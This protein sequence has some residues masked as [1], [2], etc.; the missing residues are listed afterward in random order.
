MVRDIGEIGGDPC[1]GRRSPAVEVIRTGV[2]RR[3]WTA[4]DKPSRLLAKC[5]PGLVALAL[6][7]LKGL[8]NCHTKA[9]VFHHIVDDPLGVPCD[10]RVGMLDFDFEPVSTSLVGK[11]PNEFRKGFG[12]APLIHKLCVMGA[13]AGQLRASASS[14]AAAS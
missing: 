3:I 13:F 14:S 7:P 6:D 12:F 9:V 10:D 11:L 5:F 1:S 8:L 4:R 2:P